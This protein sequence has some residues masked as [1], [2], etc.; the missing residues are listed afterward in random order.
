MAN[1]NRYIDCT[2]GYIKHNKH[3]IGII[4]WNNLIPYFILRAFMSTIKYAVNA[5]FTRDLQS[6]WKKMNLVLAGEKKTKEITIDKC[7]TTHD[8]YRRRNR[9]YEINSRLVPQRIYSSGFPVSLAT[10][11]NGRQIMGYV[12]S[13]RAQVVSYSFYRAFIAPIHS[14]VIAPDAVSREI[15]RSQYKAIVACT[16]RV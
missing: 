11:N 2:H 14:F 10:R 15:K 7:Y 6:G 4:A 1:N 16:T 13:S 3:N 5:L 9:Y 8:I 12:K